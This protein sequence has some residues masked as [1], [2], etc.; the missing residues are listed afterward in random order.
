MHISENLAAELPLCFRFALGF[1]LRR[2]A[3]CSPCAISRGDAFACSP[4]QAVVESLNVLGP[5]YSV[6][7]NEIQHGEQVVRNFGSV[8]ALYFAQ[9]DRVVPDHPTKI[10]SLLNLDGQSFRHEKTA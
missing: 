7:H 9:L 5:R 2:T 3:T 6:L 8:V 10:E 1:L 4:R